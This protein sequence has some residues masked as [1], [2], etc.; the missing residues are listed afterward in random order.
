MPA[1]AA[2]RSPR[3]LRRLQRP[4]PRTHRRTSDKRGGQTLQP[5]GRTTGTR[6]AQPGRDTRAGR[7][8]PH[9]PALLPLR[10]LHRLLPKHVFRNLMQSEDRFSPR[11]FLRK[12]TLLFEA[13]SER[14]GIFGEHTIKY[15]NGGLFDTASIVQLDQRRPRNPLRGLQELRLVARGPG[16]LRNP[17][18]ALPRSRPPLAH[19]RALHQ[20][21]RYSAAHRAGAH[22][23]AAAA[24]G[25]RRSRRCWK[26]SSRAAEEAAR[27]RQA[28]FRSGSNRKGGSA[29]G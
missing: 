19:R 14:D 1:P 13:M 15:F 29:S 18:R 25:R 10:R 12:L 26:R 5:P 20:R 23:P 6:R 17:L 27:N 4:P 2:R 28:R 7:A 9:A 21:R 24:L 3:P 16:H 11:R 22:A 8:L